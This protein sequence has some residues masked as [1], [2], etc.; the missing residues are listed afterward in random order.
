MDPGKLNRWVTIQRVTLTPDG[1]GGYTEKWD[2]IAKVKVNATPIAGKEALVG[3]TLQASQ[4]WRF[5][6]RYREDLSTADRMIAKWLPGKIISLQS[7]ADRGEPRPG[8]W[9]IVFG[10][11]SAI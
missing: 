6:M 4:P 9:L 3:G 1:S 8:M 10:T 2:D 7:V 5:E 11:A